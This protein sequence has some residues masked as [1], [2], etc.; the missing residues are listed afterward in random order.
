VAVA[1][2]T[3]KPFSST[4][5]KLL[6]VAFAYRAIFKPTSVDPLF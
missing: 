5:R 4:V 3:L 6:R 1:D 2:V